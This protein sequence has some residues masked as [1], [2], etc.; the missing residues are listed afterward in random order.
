MGSVSTGAKQTAADTQDQREV[1][2]LF[3]RPSFLHTVSKTHESLAMRRRA[4]LDVSGRKEVVFLEERRQPNGFHTF[5]K[6]P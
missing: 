4:L 2:V 5:S 6:L 1:T 3:P